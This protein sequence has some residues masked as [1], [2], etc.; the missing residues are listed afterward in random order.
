MGQPIARLHTVKSMVEVMVVFK[1]FRSVTGLALFVQS[2]GL[3]LAIVVNPG[4]ADNQGFMVLATAVIVTGWVGG[5]VAYAFAA[6]IDAS[7]SASNLSKTLD[8][9]AAN[10]PP[11][12]ETDRETKDA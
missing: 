10:M 11:Q 6:G 1:D 5:A 12:T 9:A 3:F 4:L 8:I 2:S 7:K